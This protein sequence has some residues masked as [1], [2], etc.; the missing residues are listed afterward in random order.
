VPFTETSPRVALYPGSFDILTN[1]HLDIIQRGRKLFDRLVVAVAANSAKR[2]P[3][4]SLEERVQVLHEVVAPWPNV[5]PVQLEGLTVEAARA[6]G[7]RFIL[8]GLRAVSDFEFELQLAI[9]NHQLAPDVESIF[10]APAPEWIF[11]SSSTVRE[12]WRLGGDVSQ[13]VPPP[14]LAALHRKRP[15]V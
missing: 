6:H 3:T 2:E 12:V 9:M 4:F 1:G 10:L 8:R 5:Q 14:V 15:L 7:A 11:L 13:F